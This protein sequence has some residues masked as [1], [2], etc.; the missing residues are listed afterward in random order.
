MN[1]RLAKNNEPDANNFCA[2][3]NSLYAR[4]VN[5]SYYRWQFFAC[6]FPSLLNIAVDENDKLVGSYS[7][8][9]KENVAW[10]LDIMV[11]PEIQRQGV[12]RKLV[13]FGFEN[14]KDYDVDAIVVMANEKADKACVQGLG[15]KRINTFFTY[16]AKPDELH[17]KTKFILEFEKVEN[18]SS[19][20]FVS[21]N[22]HHKNLFSNARTIAYQ[23][24]R[25]IENT[26]YSYDIF[27]SHKG[28][29]PFGYVVMKTFH[30][31]LSGQSFGDIVDILWVEDDKDAL[32]EMLRFSLMEFYKKNVGIAAMWLQTNTVLDEVGAA[33][34]FKQSEQERY[35]CGKA[36]KENFSHLENAG[37]WFINM[38]DSEVY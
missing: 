27:V 24:W 31:P 3:S 35:F 8:H 9:V 36:L 1:F 29:S 34:G 11:S 5:E 33:V 20:D 38:S 28:G 12:F 22:T 10:I 18:F 14:L 6:P 23:N 2:L 16:F 19:C 13:D 37:S 7:L 30:D 25:F 17:N 26:R 21:K 4:P 15:W 32:A